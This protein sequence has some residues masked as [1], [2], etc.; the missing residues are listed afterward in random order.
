MITLELITT[1]SALASQLQYDPEEYAYFI[2]QMAGDAPDHEDVAAY[3]PD[4]KQAVG[5]LRAL[6][7][8]IEAD[9]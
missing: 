3:I 9:E 8:A 1:G 5:Y 6:A 4:H 2:D 7:D